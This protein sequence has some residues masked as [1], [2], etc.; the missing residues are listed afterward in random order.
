MAKKQTTANLIQD[1]ESR[2]SH[3]MD[4]IAAYFK[5]GRLITVIVRSPGKPNQDFLMTSDDLDEV[6]ALL[7]RRR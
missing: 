5:P 4:D 1:V 7:E 2:V 3:H 6:A